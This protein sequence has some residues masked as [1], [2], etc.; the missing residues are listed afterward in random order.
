LTLIPF[1][2]LL[3]FSISVSDSLFIARVVWVWYILYYFSLF[4]YKIVSLS[5]TNAAKAEYIPYGIG[6]I[7]GIIVFFVLPFIR[8][9][10]FKGELE[11]REESGDKIVGKA[12][13][14]HKLQ[15]KELESSYGNTE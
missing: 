6:I 5:A 2:I 4:I 15:A 8:K 11:A 14:L 3:Y 12:K 10:V 1:I 13:L 9:L 7:G